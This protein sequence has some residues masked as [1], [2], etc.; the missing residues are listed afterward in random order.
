MQVAA[1]ATRERLPPVRQAVVHRFAV[2]GHE[3]YMI[4]GLY[5]DGR[6]GELFLCMAK[7]GSTMSGFADGVAIATSIALQYG[8]PLRALVDKFKHVH[9]EPSGATGNTEIPQA[10]S[11]LDYVFRWLELRF[12]PE[13]EQE[14]VPST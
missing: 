3:G 7:E 5:P 6:P 14:E 12:L 8:V 10:A 9:F 1:Q 11:V 4:V 2:A 13:Q